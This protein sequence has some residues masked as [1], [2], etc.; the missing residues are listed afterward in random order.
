MSTRFETA[1]Q[2]LRHSLLITTRYP[3]N[4]SC[5]RLRSQAGEPHSFQVCILHLHT[6]LAIPGV[7]IRKPPSLCAH[8]LDWRQHTTSIYVAHPHGTAL[9][10]SA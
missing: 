7:S 2:P 10:G 1:I 8:L 6:R 5:E 3:V 9:R 4:E